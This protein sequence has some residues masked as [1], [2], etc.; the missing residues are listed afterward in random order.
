M[1]GVLKGKKTYVTAAVTIFG[2]AASYLTGDMIAM[3]AIQLCITAV[4][5]STV[6]NG[7]K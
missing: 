7:I 2:A 5:A 4:F 3:D 6:R 1:F